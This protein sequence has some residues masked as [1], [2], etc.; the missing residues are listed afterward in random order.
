MLADLVF[1]VTRWQPYMTCR[2]VRVPGS[3]ILQAWSADSPLSFQCV[4]FCP[5]I[6]IQGIATYSVTKSGPEVVPVGQARTD[7]WLCESN[8]IGK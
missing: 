5:R 8:P 3:V 2:L 6:S 4:Q 1:A 7:F